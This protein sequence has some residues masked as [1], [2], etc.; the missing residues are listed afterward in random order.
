MGTD[1][2]GHN[3][4]I[5]INILENEMWNNVCEQS[6]LSGAGATAHFPTLVAP[7]RHPLWQPPRKKEKKNSQ[8][9]AD[10]VAVENLIFYQK[11][12]IFT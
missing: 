11:S 3:L 9:L 10:A 1:A 7:P 6:L 8:S 5:F 12:A 2:L 4:I